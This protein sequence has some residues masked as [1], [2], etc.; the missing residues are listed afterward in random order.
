MSTATNPHAAKAT[1]LLYGF[2]HPRNRDDQDWITAS[3]I[4]DE[5][6]SAVHFEIHR[7]LKAALGKDQ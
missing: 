1:D 3:K 4:V 6:I 5:I 2:I 7:E